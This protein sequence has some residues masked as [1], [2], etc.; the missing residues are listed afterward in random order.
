MHVNVRQ[1]SME[2][3]RIVE[4]MC[5]TD[6]RKVRSSDVLA[7]WACSAP[8]ALREARLEWQCKRVALGKVVCVGELRME[9]NNGEMKWRAMCVLYSPGP[10]IT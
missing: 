1:A 5:K 3:F 2:G 9:K 10:S 8:K 6:H 4:R 7:G